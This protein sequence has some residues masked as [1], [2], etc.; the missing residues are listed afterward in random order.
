[1]SEL[2]QIGAYLRCCIL[3]KNAV[4]H[5][6]LQGADTLHCYKGSQPVAVVP[7][8][9]CIDFAPLF[10]LTPAPDCIETK[11]EMPHEGRS[12]ALGARSG[13]STATPAPSCAALFSALSAAR[14]FLSA[15]VVAR[16]ISPV[17]KTR[18]V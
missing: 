14:D 6:P 13:A 3:C 9:S 12:G 5:V 16:Q 2:D 11:Y 15:C 10:R 1:V 18:G 8:D 17:Y 4:I 7:Y